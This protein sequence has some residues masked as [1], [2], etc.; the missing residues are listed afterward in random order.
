MTR[1][2][3]AVMLFFIRAFFSLKSRL[4]INWLYVFFQKIFH[5]SYLRYFGV[6]VNLGDVLLVGLPIIKRY[7]DSRIIIGKGVTLV[8]NSRGNVAGVNH[9]VILATLAKGAEIQIGDG[10]GISGSSLCAVKKITIGKH[11]G[12]GSNSNI[13]DTDFHAMDSM[14]N[15]QKGI[16]DAHSAPV[17]IG[18]AV[19]IAGSTIILKGVNIG[20]GAV[21]GAGAVVRKDVPAN[22]LAI[23]NPAA[24]IRFSAGGSDANLDD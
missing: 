12:L 6:E 19:W 21:I 7:K 20:D 8:S 22:A 5:F 13:Y 4:T 11:T 3:H 17:T 2:I 18:D 23:G 9:P 10:V 14:A 1:F 16:L 15:S 24:V